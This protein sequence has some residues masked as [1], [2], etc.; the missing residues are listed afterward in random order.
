MKNNKFET[1]NKAIKIV[2]RQ[3]NLKCDICPPHRGE[4]NERTPRRSWKSRTKRKTQY[5]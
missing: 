4:N 1:N 3:K 5:K 2:R